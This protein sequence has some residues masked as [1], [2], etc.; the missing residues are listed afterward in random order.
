[1]LSWA[2]NNQIR[3]GA[4]TVARVVAGVTTTSPGQDTTA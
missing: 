4:L 2:E 1:M 3:G